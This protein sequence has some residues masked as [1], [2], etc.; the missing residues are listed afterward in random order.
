V[1]KFLSVATV[2]LLLSNFGMGCGDTKRY[3]VSGAPVT[4]ETCPVTTFTV[5]YMDNFSEQERQEFL[6][7]IDAIFEAFLEDYPQAVT[8]NITYNITI[9]NNKVNIKINGNRILT[10]TGDSNEFP[11]LYEA[12]C[13]C[14]LGED[15]PDQPMWKNRG[16]QIAHDRHVRNNNR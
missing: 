11:D 8:N 12:L 13:T 10:W 15:H 2:L 6:D 7:T 5:I 16:Q 3:Y 14:L 9:V 4:T 1:K